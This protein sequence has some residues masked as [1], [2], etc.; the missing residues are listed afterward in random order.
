M[1]Q[2]TFN[3]IVFF[4]LFSGTVTAQLSHPHFIS[5][6]FGTNVPLSDYKEADTLLGVGANPG[7]YYSFEAGAFFSKV[8]GFGVNIGGFNNTS[9]REGILDQIKADGTNGSGKFEVSSEDWSNGYIMVGP[10]LSFGSNQFIVDL[11]VLAGVVNSEKPF[12]N[13]ESKENNYQ[14]N[15][16][17]VSNTSFG[18]NY[19]L[20]F[21]IKLVGKLALRLNAEGILSTQEFTQKVNEIDEMGNEKPLQEKTITREISALNLGAGLVINL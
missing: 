8:L 9:E 16:S 3:L 11:K 12:V 20:H 10:Y 14:L 21:R 5:L 6:N 7:L 13:I 2:Y 18:V 17:A 4:C 15:S 1:K 19:G